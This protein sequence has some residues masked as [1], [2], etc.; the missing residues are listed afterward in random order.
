MCGC[1]VTV[2]AKTT[3]TTEKEYQLGLAGPRS[4]YTESQINAQHVV[5]DTLVRV[6]VHKDTTNQTK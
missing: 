2:R 4:P 5:H 6:R 3:K 1:V